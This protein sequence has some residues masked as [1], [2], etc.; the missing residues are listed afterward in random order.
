MTS[1]RVT[2]YRATKD[3]TNL[4][5]V[6]QEAVNWR[7]LSSMKVEVFELYSDKTEAKLAGGIDSVSIDTSGRKIIARKYRF[8]GISPRFYEAYRNR[9]DSQTVGLEGGVLAYRIVHA[10]SVEVE[11]IYGRGLVGSLFANW[12]TPTLSIAGTYEKIKGRKFCC[13]GEI[14]VPE[15]PPAIPASST[16]KSDD[17]NSTGGCDGSASIFDYMSYW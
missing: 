9:D 6:E 15:T 12:L 2:N 16:P 7:I 10:Y 17:S 13:F 1:Y 8:E 3:G 5:S 14:T 11:E 4:A